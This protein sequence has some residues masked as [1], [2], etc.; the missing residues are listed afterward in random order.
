MLSQLRAVVRGLKSLCFTGVTLLGP[1]GSIDLQICIAFH[2]TRKLELGGELFGMPPL[3][4]I[5]VDRR[6]NRRVEVRVVVVTL[7]G[8]SIE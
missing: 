4:R 5:H 7:K 2:S 3:L 1:L 6:L 8:Y